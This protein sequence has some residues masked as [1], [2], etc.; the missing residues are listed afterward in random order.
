MALNNFKEVQAFIT[1]VM[2]ENKTEGA[3]PPKSPHKAFWQSMSYEDFTTGNVPG[4]KDPATGNAI[5]IL[6]IGDSA[7]SNLI[8]ALRGEGPL[9]NPDHGAFGRMPANNQTPFS[10]VQIKELADW[11]DKG[12]PEFS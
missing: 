1:G 12:C 2:E 3:P 10:D 4:V 8:L 7:S 5:S 11:I 6:T 9:F